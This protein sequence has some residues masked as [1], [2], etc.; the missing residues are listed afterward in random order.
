MRERSSVDKGR[1]RFIEE[2]GEAALQSGM[3]H[4]G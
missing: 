4:I 3:K 1:E 2:I